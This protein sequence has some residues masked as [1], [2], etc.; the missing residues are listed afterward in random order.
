MLSTTAK[1]KA[2]LARRRAK[3]ESLG[4]ETSGSMDVDKMIEEKRIV[5]R[6]KS[7]PLL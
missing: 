5:W 2:R 6:W 4:I 7:M 3:E 1:E